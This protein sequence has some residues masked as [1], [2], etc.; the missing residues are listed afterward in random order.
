M[1]PQFT[2][3]IDHFTNSVIFRTPAIH[4]FYCRLDGLYNLCDLAGPWQGFI[5]QCASISRTNNLD[6]K[7]DT[8]RPVAIVLALGEKG[9]HEFLMIKKAKQNG[10]YKDVYAISCWQNNHFWNACYTVALPPNH[11]AALSFGPPCPSK[12]AKSS[13]S[14]ETSGVGNV[15]MY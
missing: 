3:G 14:A 11:T 1:T 6:A 2:K 15:M 5:E 12:T 9:N 4:L 7:A 8:S 10:H 13:E